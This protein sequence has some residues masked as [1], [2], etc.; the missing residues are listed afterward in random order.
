MDQA[1]ITA[2][3]CAVVALIVLIIGSYFTFRKYWIEVGRA[4]SGTERLQNP[5]EKTLEEIH[6]VKNDSSSSRR[7][8]KASKRHESLS[9]DNPLVENGEHLQPN[10]NTKSISEEVT[11]S[12]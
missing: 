10:G 8:S 12:L 11:S 5:P 4:R 7:S 6:V 2:L 3:S 1:S 9:F